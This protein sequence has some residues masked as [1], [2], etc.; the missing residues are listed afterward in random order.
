LRL[1]KDEGIH[2]TGK[3]AAKIKTEAMALHFVHVIVFDAVKLFKNTL[4]KLRRNSWPFVGDS[5]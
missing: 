4:V 5:D 3:E 2:P 1:D